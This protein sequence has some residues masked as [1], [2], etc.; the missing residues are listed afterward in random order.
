MKIKNKSGNVMQGFVN[1]NV[2]VIVFR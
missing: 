1:I 2:S